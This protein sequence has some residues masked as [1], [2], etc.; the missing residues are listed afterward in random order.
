MPSSDPRA[1]VNDYLAAYNSFDL[2]RMFSVLAD[3]VRFEN[4]S[5]DELTAQANGLAEFRQLAEQSKGIFS[6]RE[7]RVTRWEIGASDVKVDIA[8]RGTLAQDI[9][10]GPAAGTVLELNGVSEFAFEDGKISR[11]V[12]RA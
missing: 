2:E 1:I 4:Y 12:D 11:I 7:Q 8:Y 6:E 3:T 9:P 5:G 10:G